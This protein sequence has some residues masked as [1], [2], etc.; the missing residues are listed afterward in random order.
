MDMKTQKSLYLDGAMGTMLQS[1]GLP[2]G[3]AP[4]AWNIDNPEA[5]ER[6]HRAYLDAGAQMIV[7]NTFGTNSIRQKNGKYSVPLLAKA[8]V[9]I[10]LHAIDGLKAGQFDIP[11]FIAFDVGPL[12]VFLDP[13]GDLLSEEAIEVFGETIQAGAEGA[14]CI[15]IE[16]MCDLSEAE[17]AV[18]AGKRYG[19]GL[20]VFCTLSFNENGH[21][22]TGADIPAVFAKLAACG[23]DGIGCNCGLGPKQLLTLL[24]QIRAAT[25]LPLLMCPNAG[26]PILRNGEVTYDVTPQEFAQDMFALQRSGVWGLGGCCGTTP[27]HIAAMIERCS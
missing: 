12:G 2:A 5:V 23:A 9:K 15:L 11:R 17:A 25:N 6:V 13:I 27:E 3:S 18:I 24:P 10:A 19:N 8:A 26:L 14:D 1:L 16:T 21:L 20:P 4:D 7:T 22:M